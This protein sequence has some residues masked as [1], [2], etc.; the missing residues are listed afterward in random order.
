MSN[1]IM[2]NNVDISQY[3]RGVKIERSVMPQVSTDEITIPGYD[4]VLMNGFRLEPMEITLTAALNAH[5]V[6][7][8]SEVRRT[9]AKIL[10][11]YYIHGADDPVIRTVDPSRELILPDDPTISYYG[12]VSGS[13]GLD[14]G[15]AYP[16]VSITF[17]IPDG[18][19]YGDNGAEKTVT[20][21]GVSSM[22]DFTQVI[23]GGNTPA[24]PTIEIS[25]RNT[26]NDTQITRQWSGQD[27]YFDPYTQSLTLHGDCVLCNIDMQ[28]ET[29]KGWLANNNPT[30]NFG[31]DLWSV[32][33][34]LPAGANNLS[35]V[36]GTAKLTWRERW[37]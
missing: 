17:R 12:Y 25:G 36:N 1:A 22:Y 3:F 19:G 18:C 26:S 29:A 20:L 37:I 4:G 6:G 33:F 21:T 8:V 35:I 15:Y 32:F 10:S 23:V 28:K 14:R 9:L 2:Y 7:A 11:P 13:T 30:K 16:H 5:S 34:D 31:F 27:G 24:W